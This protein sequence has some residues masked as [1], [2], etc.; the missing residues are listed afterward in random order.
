MTCTLPG[1]EEDGTICATAMTALVGDLCDVGAFDVRSTAEMLTLAIPSAVKLIC[2]AA[3]AAAECDA[4]AAAGGREIEV[5]NNK[6]E[7][8][9]SGSI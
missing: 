6:D 3:I 7:D 8:D 1:C 2:A 4:R 9:C 5:G